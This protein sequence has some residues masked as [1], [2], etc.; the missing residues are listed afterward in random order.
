VAGLA[1]AF[2]TGVTSGD[3]GQTLKAGFISAITAVAFNVVGDITLG[4][5]HKVAAF[6]SARHL[7]NIAGHAAVGCLSA[8]AS[9]GKCGPGAL[10]AGLSAAASPLIETTFPD[11][12]TNVGSLFGGTAASAVLGGLGSVAGGGKFA[13]GAVTGAF[14][15]LFNQAA[16][17]GNQ[18]P[19]GM[20]DTGV[21]YLFIPGA[22]LVVPEGGT[23]WR[24]T[25]GEGMTFYDLVTGA[26]FSMAGSTAYYG[27]PGTY[28]IDLETLRIINVCQG[29]SITYFHRTRPGVRTTEYRSN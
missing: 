11:P 7:A 6:G 3:L 19:S 27:P 25:V 12:K 4:P 15:Y 18:S 13:N 21:D 28:M 29:G 23:F 9:G 8:V 24:F 5:A 26:P 20:T 14:G 17:G 2:V 10:A 22:M 16:S 1:S